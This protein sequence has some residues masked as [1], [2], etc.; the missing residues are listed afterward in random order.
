MRIIMQPIKFGIIRISSG[1]AANLSVFSQ[2][3]VVPK[4]AKIRPYF[5][6]GRLQAHEYW[7]GMPKNR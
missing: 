1:F 4:I 3:P 7:I 5:E 6:H 2:L